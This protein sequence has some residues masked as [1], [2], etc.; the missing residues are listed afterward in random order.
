MNDPPE[1][2]AVRGRGNEPGAIP[3]T[4]STHA[5]ASTNTETDET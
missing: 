2:A 5:I 4:A 1:P 3:A